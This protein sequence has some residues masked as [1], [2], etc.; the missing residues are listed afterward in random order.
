[1]VDRCNL[2]C[3]YCRPEASQAKLPREEL[4]TF[5]EMTRLA[6]IFFSLGIK[7]VRLT[8]GEPLLRKDLPGLVRFLRRT[9]RGVEVAVTTNGVLLAERARD[10][11]EAGLDSVNV[12]LDT[13]DRAKFAKVT[14]VDALDSVLAGIEEARAAGIGRIGINVVVMRSFNLD[15]VGAFLELALETGLTV[16]FIELMDSEGG[17]V[18]TGSDFVP[19]AELQEM[20]ARTVP[21][22]PIAGCELAGAGGPSPAPG[23]ARY[24][25]IKGTKVR[26]GFVSPWREDFCD[27]CNRIRV[28]HR[29][30][31]YPCLFSPGVCD[32]KALM[33]GGAGDEELARTILHHVSGK[34][35]DKE[36]YR[37]SNGG[38]R[39][40]FFRLGG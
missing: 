40:D 3:R 2:T 1:V 4:L 29:G 10:L 15:E 27:T 35:R 33:R 23:P 21:L 34:A 36:H 16:R 38:A 13:L 14:G 31:L 8:G 5:E 32:L 20:I 22:V 7:K 28:D 26:V 17:S 12:S 25:R 37:R 30:R 6:R 11:A 18:R 9:G 24:L 19:S 39:P